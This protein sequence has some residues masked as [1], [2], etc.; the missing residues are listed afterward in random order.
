MGVA[1]FTATV[2]FANKDYNSS[3]SNTYS[4]AQVNEH[5]GNILIRYGGGGA[6]INR[7][8]DALAVGV[9]EDNLK[10]ILSEILVNVGPGTASGEGVQEKVQEIL[11]AFDGLGI[12][13]IVVDD[14]SEGA[15]PSS[16]TGQSTPTAT[17]PQQPTAETGATSPFTTEMP[18]PVVPPQ[19]PPGIVESPL[20]I[21]GATTDNDLQIQE[22]KSERSEKSGDQGEDDIDWWLILY[23]FG[24]LA[25]LIAAIRLGLFSWI[26]SLIQGIINLLGWTWD[27]IEKFLE[28]LK[29]IL[30][31]IC[32]WVVELEKTCAE[33]E[34]IRK[35]KCRK[36][37]DQGQNAC[38]QWVDQG[39]NVE[40]WADQGSY[41]CCDWIPCKWLCKLLVW[42]VKWV[43]IAVVWIA[44]WVCA[45]V[46]WVSKWVCLF[47]VW[48]TSTI[49]KVFVWIVKSVICWPKGSSN[50]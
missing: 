11:L 42:V 25:G 31:N 49:C 23:L 5:V 34:E 36:W 18:T 37:A 6:E 2:A 17:T 35:K 40:E 46:V 12:S 44:N 45:A 20:V 1:L 32:N 33:W 50:Y 27:T 4:I 16:A 8:T 21:P 41:K 14:K 13:T 30:G 38:A 19:Q 9:T 10:I 22:R 28:W 43:L 48:I 29:G 7:V 39:H 26:Q 3:I 15:I 24:G 47:W